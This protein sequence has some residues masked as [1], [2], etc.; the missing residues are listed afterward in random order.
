MSF[1]TEAIRL[2]GEYRQL[3]DAVHKELRTHKPYPIA[4]SGLCDGASD[5]MLVS[6]VEDTRS[7]RS[8]MPMLIISS[9]NVTI[10]DWV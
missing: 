4:I 7:Q 1:I 8:K 6:I 3:L 5:A 9:A 10:K 2:D